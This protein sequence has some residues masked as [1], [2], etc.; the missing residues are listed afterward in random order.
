LSNNKFEFNISHET[1]ASMIISII[2]HSNGK[3]KD[4]DIQT[5]IRA[6]NRQLREDFY[7][8]WS[9]GGTLRLEGKSATK[10]DV[11]D[12][13]DMRGDGVIY[14]WD[15]SDVEEAIG[16]HDQ[17]NRG[18]PFGFV[19]LDIALELGEEWTVT[20][21]HEALEML[22]DPEVNLMVM[23]PHPDPEVDKDV[24]HWYEMCDAVQ[25]ETYKIDGVSVANF[26]LPL[27]FTGGDEYDGRNDFLGTIHPG[28]KTLK[29]F[30][31]NPG[32]YVGFFD[33][34]EKEYFTYAR[35]GD[36]RADSRMQIKARVKGTRRS[37]RYQ[38]HGTNLKV[39]LAAQE[40][41]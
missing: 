7:P 9:I 30:S 21:S 3:L 10:P 37:I 26:V 38:R 31:V 34:Y 24:F 2:N 19:F 22:G 4:K 13:A 39:R 36:T 35:D 8:Y 1:D 11:Q 25:S 17:N 5:V 6:I 28:K 16:Y 29:S 14:L 32:G 12:L 40:M 41:K 33:P 15:K 20:L 23:G 18:I 27:Y